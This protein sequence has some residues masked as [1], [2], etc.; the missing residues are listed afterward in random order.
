MIGLIGTDTRYR[1]IVSL[2]FGGRPQRS[3]EFDSMMELELS[4]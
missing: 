2:F 4:D 3:V 1:V